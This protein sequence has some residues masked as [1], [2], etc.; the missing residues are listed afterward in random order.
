MRLIGLDPGLR[1]T[2]W[3]V[4]E[5]DGHVLRHVANGTV[6]SDGDAPIAIRLVQLYDGVLELI[7]RWRPA[8]AAVEETFVN[9]N[10]ESTLKLGLARGVVLLAPAKA[11]LPVAEY[12]PKRVKKSVVG[13]GSAAKEQVQAMIATLLPGARIAGADAADALAVAVCHAHFI[14]ARGAYGAAAGVATRK[15][16]AGAAIQPGLQSAIAA[17]LAKEAARGAGS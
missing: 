6:H 8:E 15:S 12:A 17:A 7:E 11:G 9:R 10:P 3:G 13:T 14:Q 4:I 5:T 1:N 2:G 16:A